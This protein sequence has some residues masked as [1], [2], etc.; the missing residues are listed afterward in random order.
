MGLDLTSG[1]GHGVKR[2]ATDTR[3]KDMCVAVLLVHR[4]HGNGV[5][6]ACPDA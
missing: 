6:W 4:R 1:D 3:H 2:T 5:V